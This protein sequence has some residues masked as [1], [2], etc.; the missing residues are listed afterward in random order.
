MVVGGGVDK[1]SE[2]ERERE[3]GI[4]RIPDCNFRKNKNFKIFFTCSLRMVLIKNYRVLI[5]IC[6]HGILKMP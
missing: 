4:Q 2:R 3:R 5:V 6:R 1:R